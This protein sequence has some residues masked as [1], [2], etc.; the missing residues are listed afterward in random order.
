MSSRLDQEREE[1]LQ[2]IRTKSCKT[3]LEKLGYAV[4]QSG[5]TRLEFIFEGSKIMFWP[6][7]GWHSGKT[8]KDGRG[9]KNL[10][11]QVNKNG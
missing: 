4:S 8:I 2:P 7:S 10:L 5:N 1:K 3:K 6:Y 11:K 9:F